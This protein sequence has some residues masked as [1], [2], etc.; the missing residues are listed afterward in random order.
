MGTDWVISE[1]MRSAAR[2]FVVRGNVVSAALM[3][4]GDTDDYRVGICGN[5]INGTVDWVAGSWCIFDRTLSTAMRYV[6]EHLYRLS[7]L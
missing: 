3:R 6:E 7:T 5:L 1:D 4:I 2:I